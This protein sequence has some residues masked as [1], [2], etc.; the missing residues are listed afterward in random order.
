MVDRRDVDEALAA[1]DAIDGDRDPE[2]AHAEADRVLLSAV[3]PKVADAYRRLVERNR[4]WAC[5]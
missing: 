5:G 3:P 2:G 1:L 4:W